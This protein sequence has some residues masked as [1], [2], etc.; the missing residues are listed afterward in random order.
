[1]ATVEIKS[2]FMSSVA[3]FLVNMFLL[4]VPFIGIITT[5]ILPG[6]IFG[7][8]LLENK[9][10]VSPIRKTIFLL[11]SGSLFIAAAFL[12][13]GHSF[14][15]Q[16]GIYTFSIASVS[17]AVGLLL[18]Y[19]FLLDKSISLEK[20]IL[21]A[22]GTGLISAL[23]PTVAMSNVFDIPQLFDTAFLLSVYITWQTLFGWVLNKARVSDYIGATSV[24]S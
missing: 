16:K 15:W 8:V 11:I 20:G 22:V 21:L 13:T 6:F 18:A 24:S 14:S 2:C 1:M 4:L 23:L 7:F 12:V 17:G 19:K 5:L 10:H 3:V 9:Q